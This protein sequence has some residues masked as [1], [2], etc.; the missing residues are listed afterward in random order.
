MDRERDRVEG[1]RSKRGE[2][3]VDRGR[4]KTTDKQTYIQI[5]IYVYSLDKS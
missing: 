5:S 1:M 2:S 4:K 3:W